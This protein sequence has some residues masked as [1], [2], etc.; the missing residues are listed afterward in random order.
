MDKRVPIFSWRCWA[1]TCETI[2]DAKH[3]AFS[4]A[5]V[6]TRQLHVPCKSVDCSHTNILIIH[7][8][9]LYRAIL[10]CY[11]LAALHQS[12]SIISMA[13]F[14]ASCVHSYRLSQT[15]TNRH[16]ITAQYTCIHV[17]ACIYMW[18]SWI[19]VA[20]CCYLSVSVP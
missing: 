9:V 11:V 14:H 7:V 5:S 17:C 18:C 13:M 3:H 16:R 19:V 12:T 1:H 2:T 10:S 20:S 4:I 6:W 8:H 15:G